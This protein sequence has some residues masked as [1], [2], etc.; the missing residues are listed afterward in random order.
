MTGPAKGHAS[1]C[2]C[3]TSDPM[4][5]REPF[6]PLARPEV[7]YDELPVHRPIAPEAPIPGR[8]WY[9]GCGP[10]GGRGGAGGGGR[11]GGGEAGPGGGAGV[12]PG[13]GGGGQAGGERGRGGG[14][15]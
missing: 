13:G 14:G 9:G 6:A 4:L 11:G 12:F 7:D 5:D 10:D 8:H 2:P 3:C 1:N 15:G